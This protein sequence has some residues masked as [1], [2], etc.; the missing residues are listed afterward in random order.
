MGANVWK[1]GSRWSDNGLPE[2]SIMSI[3]RRNNVVFIGNDKTGRFCE[4]RKGDYFA[5]A[6]G[7]IVQAVARA[8]SEPMKLS[9][10]I[11][12]NS[13]KVRKGDNPEFELPEDYGVG[14]KVKIIDLPDELKFSYQRRGSFFKANYSIA[15]KV[16]GLFNDNLKSKFDI[17]AKT[18]RLVSSSNNDN[19]KTAIINGRTKY[20][21]PI[22]QREYSWGE[23]QVVRFI[24]DI[25]NGFGAKEPM[26]IGT[27]QLS[28]EKYISD[29]ECEQDIIDGQQRLSTIVC[30]LK[31]LSLK[32][33]KVK[34]SIQGVDWIETRVNNGKEEELLEEMLKLQDLKKIHQKNQNRYIENMAIIDD[35]FEYEI[36]ND[37]E[38]LLPAF[39]INEFVEYILH[40][41]LFVVI[42]TVAGLSKTIQVFNAINTAGLDLNGDDL[43]KVR[44]YEYLHDIK[45]CDED[46]FREIGDIYKDVKERNSLWRKNHDWDLIN[47]GLVRSVYKDYLISKHNLR[48]D[49]YAKATD[50]FFDE[51]F[52]VLLDVQNHQE[53]VNAK[54]VDLSLD[55][56][57]SIIG[58]ICLWGESDYRN[59][60]EFISYL[61]IERSRYSRYADIA[62]QILL[63]N[64]GKPDNERLTDVYSIMRLMSRVF[65]CW[66]IEFAR[67]VS[68]VHTLMNN[69]YKLTR[70]F[71]KKKEGIRQ[72]LINWI[73]RNNNDDFKD[74]TIGKP[75]AD[76]RV[77]KD[78]IC[79]L[80]CYLDEM[81]EH[82]ELDDLKKKLAWGFY[83]I[84]HI[85]ANA[86]KEEGID[87]DW[88]LQN[89]I[90]NLMLLEP[91]I[92]KSI[93]KLPF[94]EKVN[95]TDNK[96][97]YKD[98]CYETV[99]KIMKK[100]QWGKDEI[101]TRRKEEILKISKFLFEEI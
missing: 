4:V 89:G 49:L 34:A 40:D 93:G 53:M 91:D 7:Y 37:E 55:D 38:N 88:E 82:T 96:L 73:N 2:S 8:T 66:S 23:E 18:C 60:D 69:I 94:R 9:E 36:L 95:R 78:L 76:N 58:A 22:Y 5:I 29:K 43:F 39:D 52:D 62:Y 65:F 14:V 87:I 45:G 90:G 16:I 3:F 51:L 71:T 15:D 101:E 13:I 86:N 84:E 33:P 42:E 47:I 19:A 44:L 28:Y 81:S 77:W 24:H 50:T 68:E 54:S 48:T 31:Y 12:Q 74:K 99:K 30:I 25:F 17:K 59:S 1:I 35:C 27:M 21:V 67:Q 75:I 64:E 11:A 57:R 63:S 56:L 85:H 20:I 98:S 92:N 72:E 10:L 100:E 80:S 26:F 83:D 41:I 32:F 70:N 46:A 61:L 79:V 97:C 6:D